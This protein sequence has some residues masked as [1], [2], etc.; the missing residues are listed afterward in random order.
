MGVSYVLW[1][2]GFPNMTASAL[3]TALGTPYAELQDF[4]VIGLTSTAIAWS[5]I[6]SLGYLIMYCIGY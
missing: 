5:I 3:E 4:L 2:A 1:H 6:V